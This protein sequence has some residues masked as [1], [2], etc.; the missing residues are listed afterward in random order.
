MIVSTGN[1]ANKTKAD[2]IERLR[3]GIA[4]IESQSGCQPDATC[5]DDT[6]PTRECRGCL[7]MMTLDNFE[8][9]PGE[10]HRS[11]FCGACARKLDEMRAKR[12]EAAGW[13]PVPVKPY[14]GPQ[15]RLTGKTGFRAFKM[16]VRD[17]RNEGDARITMLR[18][19]FGL[20]QAM[21][22]NLVD[23]QNST[24]P[25]CEK[26]LG[27]QLEPD[28]DPGTMKVHGAV[29]KKCI[30]KVRSIRRKLK[31]GLRKRIESDPVS[32]RLL[33]YVER[34]PPVIPLM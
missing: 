29:C 10:L 3:Q 26:A 27:Y 11:E 21:Y 14:D 1:S 25:G 8:R 31:D 20:S 7:T 34:R 16:S 12:E 30:P 19:R 4:E 33:K 18:E 23:Q 13:E 15:L 28:M 17:V 9:K 22:T 5:F 2:T 32:I 6:I 24:C